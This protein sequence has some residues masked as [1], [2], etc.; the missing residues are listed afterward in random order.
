MTMDQRCLIALGA[1]MPIG[2]KLPQVVL[3]DVLSR[4]GNIVGP[5]SAC[6]R[7]YR[8]P[9]FPPGAGP[10]YVNAAAQVESALAPGELLDRLHRIEA[11]FGR[12]RT[13]RWGARTLD[14]DLLG[15]GDLVLPDRETQAAWMR[16][17][18]DEQRE[19][20]PDRLILP[21][22]RLQDRAF[23]LV[24]LADIAPGW[25]HPVLGRSVSQMCADLP[26]RDRAAV[27]PIA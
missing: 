18:P 19:K 27:I 22:P 2:D 10:D 11:A 6:S 26:E 9:C 8:T 7:F 20:A 16:L 3:R 15:I 13:E 4:I 23:V 5:V 24:P 1:N 12:E 25:R 17:G 21:H 14:L